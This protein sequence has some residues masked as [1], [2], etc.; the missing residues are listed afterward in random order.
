MIIIGKAL[1]SDQI[2]LEQFVCNLEACKGAC[3]VE[4]DSGAP[5]EKDETIILENIY[6]KVKPFMLENGQKAVE[7][8]GSWVMDQNDEPSTP[9]VD[10]GQCAYVFFD[11]Q[12]IA[13]CAIEKAYE[14]G[15][16]N[17]KKPVSC[18][19]Y[20]IRVEK[21]PE[22]DALNYHYWP[23]CNCARKKGKKLKVRVY[24]FLQDALVRHY[25]QDWY[26]ELEAYIKYAFESEE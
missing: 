14:L 9:L 25:G 26:D 17:F 24:R 15:K 21:F 18:H 7:E 10:A 1:L 6:P 4:G 16:V 3:C 11:Q 13:K 22:Y 2:Y 19:L 5:L 23:I 12:G 8:Q 20:P